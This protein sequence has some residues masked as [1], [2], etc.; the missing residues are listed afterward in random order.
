MLHLLPDASS[1]MDEFKKSRVGGL[2]KYGKTDE[3]IS[4]DL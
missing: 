2:K 4:I 3:K 1:H